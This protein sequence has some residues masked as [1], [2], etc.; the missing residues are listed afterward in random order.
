MLASVSYSPWLWLS[1][2]FVIFY[3]LGSLP[4]KRSES[5]NPFHS[6]ALL[7]LGCEDSRML[8]AFAVCGQTKTTSSTTIAPSG[9]A[10]QKTVIEWQQPTAASHDW[11][12][13]LQTNSNTP[14]PVLHK[15][16]F[17]LTLLTMLT[18]SVGSVMI[19]S[20]SSELCFVHNLLMLR[21]VNCICRWTRSNWAFLNEPPETDFVPHNKHRYATQ[22][23][24]A[25]RATNLHQLSARQLNF[26]PVF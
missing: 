12:V 1:A 16:D 11:Y 22:I 4:G 14:P 19:F 3:V 15:S 5:L 8:T 17:M 21:C 25:A 9:Q 18:K 26:S 6:I 24:V 10:T 23:D 13:S 7:R 2:W 20:M